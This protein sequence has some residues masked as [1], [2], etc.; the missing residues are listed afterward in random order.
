MFAV[1][2]SKYKCKAQYIRS[3]DN[4]RSTSTS[5]LELLCVYPEVSIESKHRIPIVRRLFG[6]K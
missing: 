2:L 5:V 3:V 6:M 4:S 1:V